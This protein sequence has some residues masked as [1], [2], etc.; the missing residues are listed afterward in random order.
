M[1]FPMDPDRWIVYNGEL[2]LADETLFPAGARPVLYGD[3]CFETFRSY[4][5]SMLH[6]ADHLERMIHGLEYLDINIPKVL[7][8][9]KFQSFVH[10]LLNENGRADREAMVRLQVWREGG[11]GYRPE[12]DAR[13]G[14]VLT[15][16]QLPQKTSDLTLATVST[17]RIPEASL[18]SRFKLSGGTNYIRAATEAADM[19]A[20]DALMLTTDGMV[21]ETTI[22]NVFWLKGNSVST[23]S[24]HCDLLPGITRGIV[25]KLLRRMGDLQVKEGAFGLEELQ[26]AD[27]AWVCNSLREI[28]PVSRLD[29]VSYDMAHPIHRRLDEAFD[30]YVERN[31]EPLQR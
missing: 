23:P 15:C 1:L 17:R 8:D 12:E 7:Q 24:E 28:Q 21:S 20:D 18:A 4:S 22:A 10:K 14:Y 31:L 27:A 9:S 30:A 29:D 26:E 25:L 16:G 3:G 2:R 5:G 19:G 6:F 13:T 11:R